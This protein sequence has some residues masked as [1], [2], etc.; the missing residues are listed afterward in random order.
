MFLCVVCCVS[1]LGVVSGVSEVRVM[2]VIRVVIVKH[3]CEF[4]LWCYCWWV[5]EEPRNDQRLCLPGQRS[6]RWW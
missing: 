6:I 3:V 1:G 5:G 4:E 2:H